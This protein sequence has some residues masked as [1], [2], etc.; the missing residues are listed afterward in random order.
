MSKNKKDSQNKE[1][2]DQS[3]KQSNKLTESDREDDNNDE[4]KDDRNQNNSSFNGDMKQFHLYLIDRLTEA[5][6]NKVKN[7][8]KLYNDSEGTDEQEKEFKNKLEGLLN[9]KE[10]ATYLPMIH[11]LINMEDF[12]INKNK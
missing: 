7:L 8:I 1:N 9:D 11:A 3:Y 2:K 4:V 6:L 10:R 12:I 5:K